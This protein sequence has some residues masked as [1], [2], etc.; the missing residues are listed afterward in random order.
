MEIKRQIEI[1]WP[2]ISILVALTRRVD[3]SSRIRLCES[4]SV[5]SIGLGHT[6]SV[7]GALEHSFDFL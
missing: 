6:R 4:A 1:M 5:G 3:I 7:S 2:S